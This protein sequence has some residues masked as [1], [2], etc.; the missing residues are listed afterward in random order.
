MQKAA[1][2]QMHQQAYSYNNQI[3]INLVVSLLY[4][5]LIIK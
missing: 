1:G 4:L 2:M 3:I 5:K